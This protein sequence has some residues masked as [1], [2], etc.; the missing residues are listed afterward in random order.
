MD[1]ETHPNLRGKSVLFVESQLILSEYYA[2]CY[3]SERM[4][5]VDIST[6]VP[7]NLFETMEQRGIDSAIL[8]TSS[9]LVE[10][11]ILEAHEAGK[12]IIV[13]KRN[14]PATSD[15]A[16]MY[17]RFE[18]AGIVTVEKNITCFETALNLL[19]KM[20]DEG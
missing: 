2:W 13:I 18:R 4:R 19:S 10:T 3:F 16:E 11:P 9:L 15:E 17:S 14:P 12:K 7:H 1:R 8:H 5:R 6:E 20:F